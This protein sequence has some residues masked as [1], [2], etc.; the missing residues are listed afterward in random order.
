MEKNK[1]ASYK[2]AVIAVSRE[3]PELFREEA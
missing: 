3:N 1:G 2:D